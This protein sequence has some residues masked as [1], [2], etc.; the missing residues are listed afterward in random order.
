MSSSD[1]FQA[2]SPEELTEIISGFEVGPMLAVGPRSAVF[3]AIQTS[4]DRQVALRVYSPEASSDPEQ[5][6]SV[7]ATT[8]AMAQLKHPNLIGLYDSR[9]LDGMIYVVMEFVA[10]KSL[11]RSLGGTPIHHAQARS[12]ISGI[13]AGLVHAHQSKIAHGK[14]T[15]DKILLN[16][17]AE[18][19]IGSFSGGDFATGE[20]ADIIAVGRILYVM[21]TGIEDSPR[22]VEP[23]V[24]AGS[25]QELDEIWARCVKRD[26]ADAFASV[27]EIVKVLSKPQKKA[28]ATILAQAS[29]APSPASALRAAAAPALRAAA[30][31]ALHVAAAPALHTATPLAKAKPPATTVYRPKSQWVL[32][33]NLVI[34]ILLIIAIIKVW[35]MTQ[36]KERE[37]E[38]QQ[39]AALERAA[40]L[41]EQQRQ[42]AKEARERKIR[43][44]SNSQQTQSKQESPKVNE[45]REAP[46]PELRAALADGKRD[47]LPV[48][49]V[50]RADSVYLL[51]RDELTWP[52]ATWFAEQHGA[53]LAIP[54]ESADVKWLTSIADGQHFWLGAG[55]SGRQSWRL[56]D[57]TPWKPSKEPV[58][59]GRYLAADKYGF[60]RAASDEVR[61]PFI[62]Q[63]R[64]NG[65]NPGQLEPVL[66]ATAGSLASDT[67]EYPPGT[68]FVAERA[69]LVVNRD[70]D[71][72]A[73]KKFADLSGGHL[74]VVSD[75]AEAVYIADLARPLSPK[76]LF[77]L[78]AS[79]SAEGW[80]WVTG[81]AWRD[82]QVT[83]DADD[84]GASL[85]ITSSTR[86]QA[87]NASR[88]LSGFIIEWSRDAQSVSSGD[89]ADT[90]NHA[91]KGMGT[92]EEQ[93]KRLV[94]T[95]L[96]KRKKE[97]KNNASK[98]ESDLAIV[99]RNM[100][101]TLQ[102]QWSPHI[103]A[104]K[105]LIV[106]GRV[107][108]SI[109][110]TEIQLNED[111]SKIATY[112]KS[113]QRAIDAEF[114]EAANNV[115]EAYQKRIR[116]TM[117]KALEGNNRKLVLDLKPKLDA[118]E[119]LDT[120][121]VDL[122][123][124]TKD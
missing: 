30:A 80:K 42:Q 31:P 86:L 64:M 88:K 67:P 83:G 120:W 19:K 115:R 18:P 72:D 53:H 105:Q 20:T 4:L 45:I 54:H 85:C 43:E 32:V 95:A 9:T 90:K 84:D 121:L 40:M 33:R 109:D 65:T 79:R 25:P 102:R 89:N 7:E 113:K 119:Q 91:S 10:G 59:L 106:G 103:D 38:R 16:S 15:A 46:L 111:M 68:H 62:L 17:E 14:L 118:S 74:A 1:V 110:S 24:L 87:E 116:D 36:R 100:P 35:G 117:T 98:M 71:W 5:V 23:S 52:E 112:A 73:A 93:A 124:S 70:V 21:L 60:L 56:V 47:V 69:Y 92:V 57:G 49:S 123:V 122:G 55:K 81:E 63:W 101:S 94:Q 108:E 22:S 13:C 12:I 6:Q 58:G 8:R 61:L 51:V 11:A 28:K 41:Q 29:A 76:R 26:H 97:L 78:G 99:Y 34:I 77:W 48:E 44:R 39:K 75:A 114:A 27:E 82:G 37:I 66:A 96:E 107:P 104:L 3:S 2:P 50:R